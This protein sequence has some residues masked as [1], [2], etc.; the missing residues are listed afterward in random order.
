MKGGGQ[1]I[2]KSHI[3]KTFFVGSKSFEYIQKLNFISYWL[4]RP[5]VLSVLN[6]E[7]KKFFL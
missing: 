3:I 4:K 6:I 1:K 2:E 5:Y 7:N